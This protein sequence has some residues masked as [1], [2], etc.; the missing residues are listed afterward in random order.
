MKKLVISFLLFIC[1]ITVVKAQEIAKNAIG[2]RVGSYD[3]FIGEVAYQKSLSNIDRL[4]FDL[5]YKIGNEDIDSFK[6]TTLYQ[7]VWQ[8]DKHYYWFL[9]AGGGTGIWSNDAESDAFN[10]SFLFATG[11]IGIE[12]SFTDAPI[13]VAFDFR[14]E[15]YF[16][17]YKERN[18]DNFRSNAG[19]SIKYRF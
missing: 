7:W 17:D 12:Y 8:I 19:L 4:E 16:S 2:I 3:S 9:G 6:F 5:G 13:V 18:Q 1:S 11:D 14:P 15:M 10:G